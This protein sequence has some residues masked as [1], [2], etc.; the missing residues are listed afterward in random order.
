M[1]PEPRRHR[2]KVW[3]G[4]GVAIAILIAA[5]EFGPQ[6]FDTGAPAALPPPSVGVS[7]PLQRDI[8]QKLNF[9]GQF[10][11]T[12]SVEIRAQVGG[13]LT[14]VSFKDGD[15]VHQGR[16]SSRSTR[17][18]TRSRWIRRRRSSRMRMRGSRWQRASCSRATTEIRPTRAPPKMLIK[19]W[20]TR[21]PPRRPSMCHG[22]VHDARF[23]L[24]KQAHLRAVHGRIGTHVVSLGNLISGSRAGTSPTTLL[25]HARLDWIRLAQLRHERGRLHDVPARSRENAKP[26]RREG[27]DRAHRR[28]PYTHEGTLDFIDNTL[29]RT[30]GTI[31]ARA[32]LRN[33]D[34]LLTPGGVRAR[35]A[36][37]FAA[38]AR[39]PC[40][41]R[42]RPVR[43]G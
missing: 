24:Q 43:P 4:T 33:N 23:D 39:P 26:A 10:A 1:K 7:Q 5:A 17:S 20:P 15:I 37:G 9:L 38:R 13:T 14:S 21:R 27:A 29:D 36:R 12:R 31:H 28:E 41:G 34:S 35:P 8:E 19:K 40:A 6:F 22:D 42:R 32:T 11:A 25:D 3:L 18:P 30:S 2:I 16:C